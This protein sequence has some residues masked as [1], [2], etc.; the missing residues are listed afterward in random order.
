MNDFE[1]LRP[2]GPLEKYSTARHSLGLYF[3]VAVS[4]TYILPDTFTLPLKDYVY[5]ACETL[6]GQHP[7]LSAIPVNEDTEDTWFVRLPEIDL[8]Q[9]VAFQR[10]T[11]DFPND[12]E[13]DVE[14][15]ELL[16]VQHST[17]FTAPLPFWRLYILT[18]EAYDRR[19]TAVYVFHHAIGDGTSGKAFHQTFLDALHAASSLTPGEV[20]QVIPSPKSPLLPNL[21]ALHPCPTTIPFLLNALFR[22]KV[23][24]PRDS[25]L[26]TG[27]KISAPIETKL[28]QIVIPAAVSAALRKNCRQNNA[29]VTSALQA[30]VARALFTHLPEKYTRVQMNGA[31]SCRRW[32]KGG[33]VTD[34]SMGVWVMDF[35]ESFYRNQVNQYPDTFPWGQARKSRTT[36][37]Q[38]LGREGKNAGVCLLKYI[39]NF[40][41]LFGGKIG[42]DRNESFEVSN[43]GILQ[44]KQAEDP[45]RPQIKRAMFSQTPSAL[46]AALHV[47][48][49]TGGDGCLILGITWQTGIAEPELVNAVIDTLIQQLHN[50]AR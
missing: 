16:Q 39:D 28:R 22:A 21:E 30:A 19:F 3:N 37:E 46:G 41:D 49:I 47:S 40:Q 48:S 38:A 15:C 42:K 5:K 17:G 2:V 29:T 20:N 50:A 7:I 31:L 11:R 12:D 36:I 13:P 4:A 24:S 32:L 18:D 23:W 25:R 27:A 26:W 34:Q 8:S 1:R 33:E 6:I 44:P 14:L 45:S 9:S 35:G 10:R 43:V